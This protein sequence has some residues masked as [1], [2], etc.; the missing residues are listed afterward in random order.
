MHQLKD[1]QFPKKFKFGVADADLQVIG[2]KNTIA[3]ENSLPTMWIKF[4]EESGKVH[5]N[6]TPLEGI[7]RYHKWPEDIRLMKDLAVEHY[8]TSISMARIMTKDK[9]TNQKAIDWY[10]KY[11]DELRK[12]NIKIYAT[13]YH[14]ELPQFLSDRGGWKNRETSDFLAEH[15]RIVHENLGEYIEEYILLNEPFQATLESYHRGLQAPGEETIEGGLSSIHNILL[16]QGK[17]FKQIRSLDKKIKISTTYNAVVTYAFSSSEEDLLA[18]K[19]AWGYF[20]GLLTEPLYKGEYPEYMVELF[21][22][23]MPEIKS[24]DMELIKI[25][26]ELNAF[27]VN[28]YRGRTVKYDETQDAKF[29]EVIFSDSIRNGY[30]RPVYIPPTY[31]EGLFDLLTELYNKYQSFGMKQIYITENGTCWKDEFEKDGSIND[32]FRIFY[33]KEHLK[34]IEKAILKGVPVNAYF[35]W[36]FI[37]NYNWGSGY[38]PETMYG[39]VHNDFK[40]QKRTPKQSFYWYKNV[41]KNLKLD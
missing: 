8:R 34:Q 41:I 31:S 27:G 20:T 17:M 10:K 11:F 9:K 2:E 6:A 38:K 18:A 40:T 24:G 30:G 35:L 13:L 19:Y 23:K 15:S 36:T 7:D 32:E 25:G 3:E 12:N 39:I 21:G 5:E 26:S 1:F 14:W 22:N 33:I 4:G 16:A 37:D 28:F 29:T